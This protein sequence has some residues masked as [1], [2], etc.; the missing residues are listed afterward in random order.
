MDHH[1]RTSH[2]LLHHSPT[3]RTTYLFNQAILNLQLVDIQDMGCSLIRMGTMPRLS[4]DPLMPHLLRTPR[5]NSASH[6]SL[7]DHSLLVCKAHISHN[8]SNTLP[9]NHTTLS[10]PRSMLS[11]LRKLVSC[12]HL[13]KF[14][15]KIRHECILKH[16]RL[17][18]TLK[19]LRLLV[20]GSIRNLVGRIYRLQELADQA[21][22]LCIRS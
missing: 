18:T 17:R 11:R 2:T 10:R 9:H 19:C 22:H 5:A 12:Y 21:Y 20:I 13:F 7:L 16:L 3:R 1:T 8:G 6:I 14:L 4:M 15:H